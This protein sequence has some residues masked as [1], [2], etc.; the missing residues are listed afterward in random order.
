MLRKTIKNII[1][2]ALLAITLVSCSEYQAILKTR[3]NE[4]WFRKGLEY[5]ENGDFLR[6]A[7]LLG[8]LVTPYSGTSKSDTVIMYYAKSLMMIGDYY[9]A[10]HYFQNYVKTYPS[11]DNC[12]ECQFLCGKCYYELSPKILLDQQDTENAIN[13]FQSFINLFPNSER[14]PEAEKMIKEMQDKM[15]YKNY[16][17]AKLYFDLGNYMGNNYRSA[18]IVAQNCLKKYPDTK[19]REDLSFL[20]LR[21]KYI[22]A[23]NSVIN[24]QSERFRDAI[25]EYYAFINEYPSSKYNDLANDMLKNSEK[26]LKYAESV[27]PPSEDDMDYYRN[28]GT[29]A[30]QERQEKIKSNDE[31]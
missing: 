7:N 15:A 24:K 17:T 21:A 27:I 6:S 29:R 8:A 26:G 28:F 18:V 9:S 13:E 31:E 22:Q 12:E 2:V 30:E 11:S 16:L 5:Y 4:L 10:A 1:A 3:D 25:D 19:H 20:I 14:I 23:Q